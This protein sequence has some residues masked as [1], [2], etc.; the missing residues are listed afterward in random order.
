MDIARGTVTIMGIAPGAVTITVG[1]N[2]GLQ[3]ITFS[4]QPYRPLKGRGGTATAARDSYGENPYGKHET[5]LSGFQPMATTNK[6]SKP[7]PRITKGTK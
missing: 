4:E 7:K 5:T 1:S 3:C 6:T 2:D